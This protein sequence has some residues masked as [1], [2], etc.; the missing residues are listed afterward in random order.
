MTAEKI[1]CT[2]CGKYEVE[3]TDKGCFC[4]SCRKYFTPPT[5]E[6][7]HEHFPHVSAEEKRNDNV[8]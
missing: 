7:H 3:K 1:E 8:D 2:S 4:K 6:V 5:R